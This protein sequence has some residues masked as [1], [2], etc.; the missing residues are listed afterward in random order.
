MG[1]MRRIGLIVLLS[2]ILPSLAVAQSSKVHLFHS[3]ESGTS[4]G[5]PLT[6]ESFSTISV[7]IEGTWTGT[8]TFK[9][10]TAQASGYVNTQCRNRAD[11]TMS[12]TAT[13]NGYYD[14]PGA[15][16]KFIVSAV[17]ETGSVTVSGLGSIGVTGAGSSGR[18]TVTETDGS[19]S[20]TARTLQFT[21]GTV[22][23]AGNGVAAVTISGTG[24]PTDAPYWTGAAVA[25][26]SAEVSLAALATGLVINTTG[27]PSAYAGTSCTNQVLR[28]LN[29]SGAGTCVTITSAYVD[30]SIITSGGALGT[31]SSGTLTNATGLPISTGV[32]G[33]GTGVAT[34]LATPSSANLASAVTNETGSGALV[35]G[36]AP[37]IDAVVLT[38]SV[39]LPNGT[40]VPGTCS[41]GMIYF[42]NDATAGVN[43][44][45][46]TAT[47]T[48]TLLGDGGGGGSVA[49]D[50]I[51]D[52]AGDLAVGSGSNTA[53][54]LAKGNDGDVLTISGGSVAWGAGG[55]GMTHPQV[56]AR[57]SIGF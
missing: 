43:L 34:F 15:T 55:S 24:A 20:V 9:S 16:S 2:G 31:P 21:N 54:R 49:T 40:T 18:M 53:V 4:D 52:A 57:A 41:V 26:L 50:T 19:P 30:S 44:Y 14:C 48:W 27:T 37:T 56:M 6:A 8:L 47:N 51:W 3:G 7:Q 25:G 17:V 5:T 28:L 36:T 33:L 39:R 10:K 11:G 22:T 29:A 45:G 35:F 13:S 46:C 38:T 32:S 12:A 1:L 42:D 23:D